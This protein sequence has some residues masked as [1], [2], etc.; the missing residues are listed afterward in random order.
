[1]LE[2]LKK[3]RYGI[4]LMAISSICVCLGQLFWKLSVKDGLVF[5]F[6]GF[7][8]YG[9]GAIVMLIA[10]KFGSLS[11]LQPML[12]LNYVLSIILAAT[13]LNEK[14]TLIKII[15]VLVIILG[16]ILIGGGDD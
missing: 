2:S 7:V 5:L 6:L 14:I 11:V 8:L 16:V 3:N 4:M 9:I 15:G 1:M 13:I 10:Y 12:S